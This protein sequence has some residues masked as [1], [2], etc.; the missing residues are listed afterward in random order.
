MGVHVCL[1][2]EVKRRTGRKR[3]RVE[4]TSEPH[5]DWDDMRYDGDRELSRIL[6]GVGSIRRN[7]GDPEN[8]VFWE[9]PAD[10]EALR[11]ALL[12]EFPGNAQRW[13]QLCDILTDPDWWIYFSY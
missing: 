7:H 3:N 8:Y 12:A 6:Q 11:A 5:L 4:V 1:Y 10:V 2:R 9:R 13:N